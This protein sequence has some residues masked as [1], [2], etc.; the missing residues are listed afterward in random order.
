MY[1]LNSCEKQYNFFHSNVTL[2]LDTIIPEKQKL[3]HS[4]KKPW[5]TG[6][7]KALLAKRTVAFNEGNK[8]QYNKIRNKVNRLRQS[9]KKTYYERT[10]SELNNSDAT[11]WWKKVKNILG[12]ARDYSPL[13]DL[14]KVAYD[15]DIAK[16]CD[17]INH[18]F[19]QTSSDLQ[20]LHEN[21]NTEFVT[22]QKYIIS[23]DEVEKRLLKIKTKKAVGPDKIPNWVLQDYAHIIAPPLACI[24]NSSLRQGYVPTIWRSANICPVPKSLPIV[25]IQK[26]LRPISLTAVSA[27][28]LEQFPVQWCKEQMST[29]ETQYGGIKNSNTTCALLA[30]LH[31]IFKGL[32][33]GKHYA[34]ILLVDFSKAFD[35]IDHETVLQKLHLNGV[36]DFITRWF[37]GFLTKRTQR[38]VIGNQSSKWCKV[39]GGVPQGTLSGPQLF[40]N[41]V[42]DLKTSLPT[43]KYVDDTTVIEVVHQDESSNL[44]T[45]LDTITTWSKTNKLYLNAAKTKEIRIDFRRTPSLLN[46]LVIDGSNV[47]IVPSAKLLGIT[48]SKDLKWDA[49]IN[50]IHGKA[51]SRL[52]YLRQLKRAG[53]T[54]KQLLHVYLTLIRPVTE[55]ACQ[56][57]SSG[58]TQKATALLET[59]QKRAGRIIYP[60]CS[61]IEFCNEVNIETLSQR[62]LLLC[63]TFF[64]SMQCTHHK[65][66]CLLPTENKPQ[67]NTRH[68]KKYPLPKCRT[69][70]FKSSFVP[71]CLF[72]LQ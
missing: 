69:K 5:I 9:L 8:E 33:D 66:N 54:Q 51:A 18:T 24:F 42:S 30:A 44:Q 52:H 71:W 63:K 37:R 41:M 36:D 14:A 15:D 3:V 23:V 32:D 25:N 43:I 12:I 57:W 11:K 17:A 39:N 21:S 48:I 26:D 58:L 53:L 4:N 10:V 22:P 47:E 67:Y 16:M 40:I 19:A 6:N 27:K 31:P 65:L 38:V 45:A 56:V 50:K 68:Y 70:R 28:V 59:I 29:D 2:Q 55:Y 46:P 34:R 20:P 35:H 1:N 7:F 13:L 61:Y 62:R 60:N 49:H 72:N 64:K